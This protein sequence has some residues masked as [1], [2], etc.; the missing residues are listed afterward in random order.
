MNRLFKFCLT[1]AIAVG[2]TLISGTSFAGEIDILV[3]KLVEKGILTSGEAQ[4]VLTETREE[5]RKEIVKGTYSSLP[6][7][8]QNM[9]LKGDLRLRYQW[10]DKTD[11][12]DRHRGRYRFRLGLHT[13]VNDKLSVAAGLA[14]GGSDARSTNQTMDTSF[15][16][17]DIRLDYAFAEWQATP[18]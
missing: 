6:S 13:K 8:I 7:W 10:E 18:W 5:V 1:V 17:P 11:S 15:S 4:Q 16:T 12:E 9:K 14:T 3:Q 2:F